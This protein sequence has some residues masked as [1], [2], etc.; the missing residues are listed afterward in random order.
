MTT[1]EI[2][3]IFYLLICDTELSQSMDNIVV[4]PI[5]GPECEILQQYYPETEI[6]QYHIITGN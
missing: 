6:N 2:N 4:N 5:R 1:Y 3:R